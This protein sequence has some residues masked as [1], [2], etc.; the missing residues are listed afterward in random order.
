[1]SGRTPSL[2]RAAANTTR[3]TDATRTTT[4]A[5]R[6]LQLHQPC[7]QDRPPSGAEKHHNNR[8]PFTVMDRS[9]VRRDTVQLVRCARQGNQT[10]RLHILEDYGIEEH[11]HPLID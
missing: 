11:T 6:Q 1:M 4:V 3:D 10:M 9:P 2:R 8:L 7:T 5:S